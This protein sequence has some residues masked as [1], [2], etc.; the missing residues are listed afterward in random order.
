ML[1]LIAGLG[2]T[3]LFG[4]LSPLSL[5]IPAATSPSD[6]GLRMYAHHSTPFGDSTLMPNLMTRPPFSTD[7]PSFLFPIPNDLVTFL[8]KLRE[9]NQIVVTLGNDI[10]S[11][12]LTANWSLPCL[13][14]YIPG[15]STSMLGLIA[16]FPWSCS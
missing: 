5:L 11:R 7:R 14:Q 8:H 10:T 1:I 6:S 3:L 2:C 15:R 9:A 4:L 12:S 16:L 13:S